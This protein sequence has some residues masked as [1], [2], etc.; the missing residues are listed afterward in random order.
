MT[1]VIN[2]YRFGLRGR[3]MADRQGRDG[4]WLDSKAFERASFDRM[5]VMVRR[6]LRCVY[7]KSKP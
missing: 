3:H 1:T 2:S 5:S 4:S 6:V 7:C